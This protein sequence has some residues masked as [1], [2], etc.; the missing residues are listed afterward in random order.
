NSL[1]KLF[2]GISFV[3]TMGVYVISW[4]YQKISCSSYLKK[5]LI[6]QA[7][8]FASL[9]KYYLASSLA[10][11]VFT[12]FGFGYDSKA[13]DL[14][15]RRNLEICEIKL[16]H[17][18]KYVFDNYNINI[19]IWLRDSR[20][21]HLVYNQITLLNHSKVIELFNNFFYL[22]ITPKSL[23]YQVV[24]F[25]LLDIQL[26]KMV[27]SQLNWYRIPMVIVPMLVLWWPLG[28]EAHL[29]KCHG[30]SKNKITETKNII[31]INNLQE[32][33][34]SISN[35]SN[36]VNSSKNKEK[37]EKKMIV[38]DHLY[39]TNQ[40]RSDSQESQISGK[41]ISFTII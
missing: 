16:A 38:D 36:G 13:K 4:S 18:Y 37:F 28:L 19:N 34:K 11:L 20:K 29:Q 39:Y 10:E 2:I 8:G 23:N 30:S 32:S 35:S 14:K 17:S 12:M 22:I 1:K 7:L 5:L 21:I 26:T 25:V 27:Y 33:I 31:V 15:G 41:I 9:G 40:E 6:V 3:A 24:P